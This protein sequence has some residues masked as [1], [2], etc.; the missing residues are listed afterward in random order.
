[1]ATVLPPPSKRQR[2]A[3]EEYTKVQ[4]DASLVG[5]DVLFPDATTK[6]VMVKFL[7][8]STGQYIQ[9]APIMIPAAE[10][11]QKNIETLINTLLGNVCS[12]S[13]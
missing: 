4:Q 12:T 8:K 13:T 7:D 1:M 2:V 11:T 5:P 9:A 6:T 10:T 3:H